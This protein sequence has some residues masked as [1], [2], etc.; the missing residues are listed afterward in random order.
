MNTNTAT[1]FVNK[2]ILYLKKYS[3]QI[4]T[5][6]GVGGFA[7]TVVLAAKET[8]EV[9]PILDDHKVFI[10]HHEE[11][12]VKGEINKKEYGK[13]NLLV[14][15]DI[16][17]KI[18]RL[19]APAIGTGALTLTCFLGSNKIMSQRNVALVA[20]Y[21]AL[22]GV[23]SRYR[24]E[25][26]KSIGEEEDRELFQ[27]AVANPEVTPRD[28][29]SQYDEENENYLP[30]ISQYAK[31]FDWNSSL[32]DDDADTNKTLLMYKERYLNDLLASRGHVFLNDVY[33]ELDI[34]RTKAGA[35]VGW[36]YDYKEEGDGYIDLGIFQEVNAEA[37]N[38]ATRSRWLL[39][40]NVE[41]VVYDLLPN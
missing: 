29:R 30:K 24:E 17:K 40:P 5:G 12:Y 18:A 27:R 9:Q 7:A 26:R 36:L 13:N 38:G 25:V 19:Y 4:L 20:A 3:P 22:D 35:V 41:G 1:R 23:Y 39:D 8:L 28:E 37:I 31:Y 14:L 15:F 10:A 34:P 32:Y 33:D 6:I 2:S 16:S 11:M 21:N